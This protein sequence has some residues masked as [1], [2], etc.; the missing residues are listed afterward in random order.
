VACIKALLEQGAQAL[1]ASSCSP[2]LDASVLLAHVLERESVYLRTWPEREVSLTCQREFEQFIGRRAAG[3]PVAYLLGYKDFW[4][5]RFNVDEHT[6]IPRPETELLIELVLQRLSDQDALNILDLGTGSGAIAITLAKQCSLWNVWATDISA[7]A[8]SKAR[9]NAQLLDAG[10]VMFSLGAWYEALSPEVVSALSLQDRT[11]VSLASESHPEKPVSFDAIV[12][13][14]PYIAADDEHLSAQVASSE[15]RQALIS[16]HQG[17]ADLESIIAGAS[18]YLVPGGWLMLEHGFQQGPG[19]R[20]LFE[21]YGF[22]AVETCQDL[23]GHDRCSLGRRSD[24]V[25]ME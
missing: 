22:D 4:D 8:L 13:N 1:L 12:A 18:G 6:L 9:E 17:F 2:E 7:K 14:P 16:A 15:P 3:Q 10:N 5:Y 11:D 24:T 23:A 20:D 25:A 19:V 21:Q